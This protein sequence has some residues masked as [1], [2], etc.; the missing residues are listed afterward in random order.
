MIIM[1]MI[2]FSTL[3]AITFLVNSSSVK[4]GCELIDSIRRPD[5][6]YFARLCNYTGTSV[7]IRRTMNNKP[8]GDFSKVGVNLTPDELHKISCLVKCHEMYNTTQ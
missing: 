8:D 6:L 3:L 5:G 4:P 2:M 1:S 7:V